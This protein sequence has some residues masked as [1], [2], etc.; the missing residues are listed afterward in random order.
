[1]CTLKSHIWYLLLPLHWFS[2][3]RVIDITWITIYALLVPLNFDPL[4]FCASWSTCFRLWPG[5]LLWSEGD[6]WPRFKGTQYGVVA[7]TTYNTF[8]NG[9]TQI[10]KLCTLSIH[11]YYSCGNNLAC[12]TYCL[13]FNWSHWLSCHCQIMSFNH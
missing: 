10:I 12:G 4:S 7:K 11:W 6:M 1:M 5:G 3:M 8:C 2:L 13:L 9:S